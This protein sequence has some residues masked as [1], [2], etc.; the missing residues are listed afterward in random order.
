MKY[1]WPFYKIRKIFRQPKIFLV[2]PE[3]K[4]DFVWPKW[5]TKLIIWLLI[6]LALAY[7]IFLSP[8][9][10]IRQISIEGEVSDDGKA[11]IEKFYGHNLFA[12]RGA[13]R[14]A[15]IKDQPG[16]KDVKLYRGLPDTLRVKIVEREPKYVWSSNNQDYFVDEEGIAFLRPSFPEDQKNNLAKV[17][18]LKNLPVTLGQKIAPTG[19]GNFIIRTK[20]IFNGKTEMNIVRFEIDETTFQTK[21]ILDNDWQLLLDTTRPTDNQIDIFKKLLDTHR[22]EI[23]QYADVRVEGK[24]YYK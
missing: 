10:K 13:N 4:K 9:F 6:L 21:A 7:L 8:L 24:A 2:T 1:S 15:I 18:D 5:L 3:N 11:E 12:A 16:I 14:D 19:F 17:F 23:T 22:D 20:E